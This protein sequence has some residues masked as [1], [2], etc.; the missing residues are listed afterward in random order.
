[1]DQWTDGF[2]DGRA[3][4]FGFEFGLPPGGGRMGWNGLALVDR[5]MLRAAGFSSFSILL[6]PFCIPVLSFSLGRL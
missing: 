2:L 1:M 6:S 5:E 4:G 3:L